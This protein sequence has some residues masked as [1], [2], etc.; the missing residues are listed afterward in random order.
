MKRIRR[1]IPILVLAV[2]LGAIFF[3]T[4]PMTLSQLCLGV[5]VAESKS[6][7]GYYLI[8]PGVED[9]Y[10]EINEKDTRFAQIIDLFENRKFR[11][12]LLSLLPQGTKTYPPQDGD[13]R[14][15]IMFEINDSK[16]PDGSIASGTL[17]RINNFYG[18]LEIHFN[19]DV[20][21]CTTA[22]KDKW[23]KDVMGIISSVS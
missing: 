4:R 7:S 19:G 15:E 6:V 20:W 21:R 13:F 23:L 5:T 12:S 3:Y 18:I 1:I 22:D 2:I 11:R 17:I 10:F 16:F 9:K 14:W 8:A